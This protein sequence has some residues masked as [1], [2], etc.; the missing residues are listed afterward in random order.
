MP[1]HAD[2]CWVC[3][4]DHVFDGD[5]YAANEYSYLWGQV[6]AFDAFEA[7]EEVGL[8]DDAALAAVGRRF[9]E[10]VLGPE[11]SQPLMEV[12]RHFRGKDASTAALLRHRSGGISEATCENRRFYTLANWSDII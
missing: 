6:L 10:S 2:E 4:F 9:R 12:Y 3:I 11:I 5:Q 8:D 1:A 7:F